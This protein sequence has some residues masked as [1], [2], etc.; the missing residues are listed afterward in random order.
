MKINQARCEGMKINKTH[1]NPTL[2][3]LEEIAINEYNVTGVIYTPLA[4]KQASAVTRVDGKR[5]IFYHDYGSIYTP[6]ALAHEIG[7]LAVG[8]H[9]GYTPNIL[10]KELEADSFAAGL[11]DM[12]LRRLYRIMI[13]E[14]WERFKE[15]VN[16]PDKYKNPNSKEIQRLKDMG[17][18]WLL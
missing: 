4:W 11:L 6:I 7:H 16:N 8:H 5:F 14:G 15:L 10:V 13:S 9:D 2:Q 1:P 12:P 18:Y 3:D 17:V